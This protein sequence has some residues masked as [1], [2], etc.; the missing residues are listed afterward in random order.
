MTYTQLKLFVKIAQTG[1]FTKAGIELNMTQP[2]VSRAISSLEDELGIVLLIRDKGKGIMLTDVGKQILA[3]CQDI[4]HNFEKIEQI[5]ARERGLEVGTIRV[6]AFPVASARFLPRIVKHITDRH[7]G[8][9][10]ELYEGTIDELKTWLHDRKID[11]GFILP[12]ADEWQAI[13]LYREKMY[14]VVP[15]EHPFAKLPAVPIRMLGGEPL[16]ACK[17][18]FEP[19][20]LDMFE[21]VHTEPNIRYVVHNV[22]TAIGMAQEGLGLPVL[23]ELSVQALPPG[24]VKRE[25]SPDSYRD[26]VIALPSLEEASHA[27]KLFVDTAIHL[28]GDQA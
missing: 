28:F 14:V 10:F 12:P 27:V 5:A 7:P 23:S 22:N 20:I 26:I 13:P 9:V 15:E 17:A 11:V 25:L 8:I 4:L 18:G 1:S 3:R 2:A 6:G 16:V 21:R 19:P 24:I